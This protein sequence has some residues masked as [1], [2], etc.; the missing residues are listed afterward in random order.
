MAQNTLP[1]I[2]G[3]YSIASRIL[4]GERTV[5]ATLGDSLSA[6]MDFT[7]AFLRCLPVP[8]ITGQTMYNGSS[9]RNYLGD[10]PGILSLGA[11]GSYP[12]AAVGAPLPAAAGGVFAT[13]NH[14]LA[15]GA[16]EI[17]FNGATSASNTLGTTNRISMTKT[18]I[19]KSGSTV[20]DYGQTAANLY[21]AGDPIAAAQARAASLT[22]FAILRRNA[23]GATAAGYL[24]LC[25]YSSGLQYAI[26]DTVDASNATEDYLKTSISATSVGMVD[27]TVAWRFPAST[28]SETGKNAVISYMGWDT[29]EADGFHYADLAVGGFK[30]SNYLAMAEDAFTAL[31][32]IASGVTDIFIRCEQNAET[33]AAVYETN[34]TAL[35][36]R[37]RAA[38]PNVRFI[39]CASFD[40]GSNGTHLVDYAAISYAACLAFGGLWINGNRMM[41]PNAV[42][43]GGL[44]VD[45]NWVSG[46]RYQPGSQVYRVGQGRF[47]QCI[48]ATEAGVAS[49]TAPESDATNWAMMPALSYQQYSGHV[50]GEVANFGIGDGVHQNRKG[51]ALDAMSIVGLLRMADEANTRTI[52]DKA[53]VAAELLA[54]ESQVVSVTVLDQA[55]VGTAVTEATAQSREAAAEAEG[56]AAQLA[57]DEAIVA[58]NIPLISRGATFLGSTGTA[59]LTA[60]DVQAALTAQGLTGARAV[61]LDNL[62]VAVGSRA[63]VADVD[64]NI[65]VTSTGNITVE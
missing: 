44:V 49:A 64:K 41:P 60:A 61:K 33:S 46:R 30:V 26:G 19:D 48:A 57:T 24:E 40:T 23:N 5:W 63:A 54:Q 25:R 9:R 4:A 11:G 59:V 52:A 14:C 27:P 50:Q 55:K 51:Y 2:A 10:P 42:L 56:E 12:Y 16:V 65:S 15:G 7:T 38:M 62:D 39:I 35:L 17:T 45:N 29:M 47:F 36:T 8:K 28:A 58:A 43:G 34:L 22:G 37:I 18:W 1:L 20:T 31:P 32:L 13:Q 21:Y 53:T 6:N 3:D